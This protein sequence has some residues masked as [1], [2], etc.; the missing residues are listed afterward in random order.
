MMEMGFQVKRSRPQMPTYL[1]RQPADQRRTTYSVPKNTTRDDLPA[2]GRARQ[3]TWQPHPG[4][5]ATPGASAETRGEQAA[6]APICCIVHLDRLAAQAQVHHCTQY[7]R[8]KVNIMTEC[9]LHPECKVSSTYEDQPIQYITL[10]RTEGKKSH[11]LL[12]TKTKKKALYTIQHPHDKTVIKLGTEGTCHWIMKAIYE[13]PTVNTVS[14][15]KG[16]KC[17]PK[18]RTK[19]RVP[20]LT[21]SIQYRTEVPARAAGE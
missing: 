19:T 8:E 1:L 15:E 12:I 3:F 13:N 11:D 2:G 20:A 9:A 5:G 18:I 7:H 14:T 21:V 17:F 4:A 10:D 16:W 6:W